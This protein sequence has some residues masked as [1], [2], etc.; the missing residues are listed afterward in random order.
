M[1]SHSDQANGVP[2]R[3]APTIPLQYLP[4]EGYWPY[5]YYLPPGYIP[6][7]PDGHAN[8]DGS[9][10]GQATPPAYYP[11]HL[12]TPRCQFILRLPGRSSLM[13]PATSWIAVMCGVSD[14][15]EWQ[16]KRRDA[17]ATGACP[18]EEHDDLPEGFYIA[19]GDVYARPYGCR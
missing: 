4:S 9:P 6:P 16:T 12:G 5:P 7:P 13:L 10:H 11:I 19:P 18:G 15:R 3:A 14:S 8:G 2:P 1:A 17:G